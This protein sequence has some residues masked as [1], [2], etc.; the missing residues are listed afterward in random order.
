MLL[1]Y[2]GLVLNKVLL[3]CSGL[4]VLNAFGDGDCRGSAQTCKHTCS[5]PSTSS[6]RIRQVLM[7]QLLMRQLL[8]TNTTLADSA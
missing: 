6:K 7:R 8:M 1:V 4:V 2:A 3:V 5:P